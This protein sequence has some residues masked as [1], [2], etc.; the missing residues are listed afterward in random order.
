MVNSE[1]VFVREKGCLTKPSIN[2]LY[3]INGKKEALGNKKKVVVVVNVV[4]EEVAVN[5]LQYI[6][7]INNQKK[8]Y[9]NITVFE[10]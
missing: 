1:K 4:K 10:P 3:Q 7:L 2:I 8:G 6:A 5:V 9:Y